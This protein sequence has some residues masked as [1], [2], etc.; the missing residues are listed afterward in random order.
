MNQNELRKILL[1]QRALK[2]K[3]MEE[4][5]RAQRLVNRDAKGTTE[6]KPVPKVNPEV[7]ERS[8]SSSSSGSSGSSGS[9][10]S[11]SSDAFSGRSSHSRDSNK[12]E[13]EEKP[14][15]V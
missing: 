13:K 11:S 15:G 8:Y 3:V 1:E 12:K 5:K 14:W 9:S 10:R 2:E 7:R 4:V 6:A